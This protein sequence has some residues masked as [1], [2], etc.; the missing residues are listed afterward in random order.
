MCSFVFQLRHTSLLGMTTMWSPLGLAA[1]NQKRAYCY[2]KSVR[3]SL[4]RQKYT[5]QAHE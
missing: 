4:E 3:F 1:I 2:R 5:G